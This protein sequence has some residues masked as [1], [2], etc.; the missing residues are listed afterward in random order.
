MPTQEYKK[1]TRSPDGNQSKRISLKGR[2]VR[3]AGEKIGGKALEIATE[4]IA[5]ALS[6][7]L[8]KEIEK[9]HATK[10]FSIALALAL[11][12]DFIKV[13]MFFLELLLLATGVGAAIDI[14]LKVVEWIIVNIGSLILYLFLW[15]KGWFLE[16]RLRFWWWFYSLL[17]PELPLFDAV[18]YQTV[19]VLNA[20]HH[21]RKRAKKAQKKKEKIKEMTHQELLRLNNM[22]IIDIIEE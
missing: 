18:P 3:Y 11:L 7:K 2:A 12:I 16:T 9:G 6:E 4:R 19:L 17:I 14:I 21:V 10:A 1:E 22:N 13:A 20:W 15:R 5:E 8:N